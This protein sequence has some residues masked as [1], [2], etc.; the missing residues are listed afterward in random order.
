MDHPWFKFYD[1]SVAHSLDYP[2]IPVYK[3]FDDSAR[4]YPQKPATCFMG[5]HITYAALRQ[6]SDNLAAAL[7]KMGIGAHDK[8]VLLLP[9]FPGFLIAYYA[10]LKTGAVVVPLNPLNSGPEME[11]MFNDSGAET[12][13]TIPMFLSK[14]CALQKKTKLKRII[15]SLI[16]DYLPFPLNLGHK[17]KEAKLVRAARRETGINL[18]SMQSLIQKPAPKTFKPADSDLRQLAVLIY[19]GGTTGVAKGIMLSHYSLV[20]NAHQIVA[21]GGITDADSILAVLPLFHGFGMSVCMNASILAG[22][23]IILLPRFDARKMAATIHKYRPTLAVAVPTILVALSNLTDI[24]KYSF[25]SLKVVWVG[26][27]PLTDA[28]KNNF[29]KK[30]GGRTIEGYGLTEAVTAIMANPY[31]GKHKTGSIGLPFADVTA[32]IAPLSEDCEPSRNEP[33]EIILKTPTMMMGYYNRPRETNEAIV[34]GW[35]HTGDIGYM[36]EDGYFYITDRKKDLIIVGGFNVFPR[37]I[38]EI[39][40]RHPKV[41]EGISVGLPDAYKGERIKVYIILNDGAKATPAEFDQYFRKHLTPYKVPSEI[42]FR[43]E[44]PKSAIGKI[45]RRSLREEELKKLKNRKA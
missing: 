9:N 32:R 28:I 2:E 39:L 21:W 38:D 18:L 12:A 22:V 1:D 35:L 11:F 10:L 30:T 15:F 17:L 40:Y 13:I 6:A 23:K 41:K 14:T 20:A 44:L 37:E 33:G 27:A 31:K 7:Q 25:T 8:V 45:L 24:D 42:E 4:K 29:E 34:D 36:D 26:A 3:L 43:A 19:S 16:A 5:R